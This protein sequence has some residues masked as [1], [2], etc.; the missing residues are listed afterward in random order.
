MKIQVTLFILTCLLLLSCGNN[1]PVAPNPADGSPNA[2]FALQDELKRDLQVARHASDGGGKAWIKENTPKQVEAGESARFELVYEAGELGIASG[3]IL[4]FQVS[5]FWGWSS[6]Q[7]YVTDAPGYTEVTSPAEDLTLEAEAYDQGLL[8]IRIAGRAIEAGE[9]IHITYGAG[10]KGALVDRFAEKETHFWFAVDGD[11]DGVR[12]LID[13]NPS[14]EITPNKPERLVLTLPSSAAPG[15]NVALVVALLDYEGNAGRPIETQ[16]QLVAQGADHNLPQ[17]IQLLPSDAGHKRI[18]FRVQ[19]EGV[20]RVRASGH[21]RLEGESN[22]LVISN[23]HSPLLWADLHGHSNLSD[24]TGTPEDYFRYAKEVAALDVVA[25]TDHDHWGMRFLDQSPNLWRRIQRA[26]QEAHDPKQ[27]IT[28]LGYEWTSWTHGHRHVLYFDD[29]G[30]IFSSLDPLYDDPPKLW[31]ALRGKSALTFAHHSAGGPVATN[32]GYPPDPILEPITE[33]VSVHGSSEA[34]DSPSRIYGAIPG[35][36]VRDTLDRGFVFGFVGSGDGHDGHPG[37]THLASP[38]GGLAAIWSKERSRA[39]VLEA[40]RARRVYAT[41]GPR[42]VLTTYLNEVAMGSTFAIPHNA[43][44]NFHGT[45]IAT[46]PIESIEIIRSGEMIERIR[47]NEKQT[48]L[49]FNKNLEGLK[50]GEYVYLRVVQRDGGLAW[51]SPIYLQSP[52]E[53]IE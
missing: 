27:L 7:P 11:G 5:P 36:F 19:S 44:A 45:V 49:R 8:G 23:D 16:L 48:E 41:N 53:E 15:D 46:T 33:I 51:S 26:T 20:L 24:G 35:N 52:E 1:D 30:E 37:L 39:A 34:A 40:L 3:G 10:P 21:Q 29:S 6:P 28:L 31:S 4:F 22:P 32:W 17:S 18:P 13:I 38:S 50:A 43:K 9:Q 14:V 12:K 42:I 25:L 47:A 2:R